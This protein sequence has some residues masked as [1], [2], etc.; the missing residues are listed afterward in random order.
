MTTLAVAAALYWLGLLA[1]LTALWRVADDRPLAA[2]GLCAAFA[3]PLIPF[4]DPF[5]E[6]RG[7][8]V[9]HAALAAQFAQ[10]IRA[11]ELLP[12]VVHTDAH[13]GDQTAMWSG[14]LFY[15]AASY[16][17]VPLG[18][19]AAVK[20]LAASAFALLLRR[21]AHLRGDGGEHVGGAELGLHRSDQL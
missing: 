5:A 10:A 1:F 4:A 12:L 3:A 17:A 16:L 15:L 7:D 11:G 19:G 21:L 18:G 14:R 9:Q 2:I 8:F 20:L 13:I 6:L